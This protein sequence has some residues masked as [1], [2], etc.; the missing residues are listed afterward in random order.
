MGKHK[1]HNFFLFNFSYEM[2]T[3]ETDT[4]EQAKRWAEHFFHLTMLFIYTYSM[5]PHVFD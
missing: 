1:K 2:Q 3:N 4:P 5:L